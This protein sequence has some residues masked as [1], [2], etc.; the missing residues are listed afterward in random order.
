L[1]YLQALIQSVELAGD[2]PWRVARRL[3]DLFPE[4]DEGDATFRH[5]FLQG[6]FPQTAWKVNQGFQH[7]IAERP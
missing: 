5:V 4:R 7:K 1:C 6:H 3:L 2:R